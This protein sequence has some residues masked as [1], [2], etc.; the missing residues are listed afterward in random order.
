[1]SDGRFRP[2]TPMRMPAPVADHADCPETSWTASTTREYGPGE[3]ADDVG[4]VFV[5]VPGM[6]VR[7]IGSP[8]FDKLGTVVEIRSP[9]TAAVDWDDAGVEP[10]EIAGLELA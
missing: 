3:I 1:M 7:V 8:P 9:T 10:E 5:P 6:R 2:T 4:P